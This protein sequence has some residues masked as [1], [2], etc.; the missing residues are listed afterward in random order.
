MDLGVKT[1][2]ESN[3]GKPVDSD[4][5]VRGRAAVCLKVTYSIHSQVANCVNDFGFLLPLP[6]AG[7]ISFEKDF[8]NLLDILQ[9]E[10]CVR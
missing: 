10:M 9:V 6:E 1:P 2:S 8:R 3:S 5:K 4:G 7:R